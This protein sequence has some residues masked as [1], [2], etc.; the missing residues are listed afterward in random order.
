[1]PEGYNFTTALAEEQIKNIPYCRIPVKSGTLVVF[2]NYQMIHR[3]LR[4][5]YDGVDSNTP[6][7][8]ASRDFLM[9]FIVDQ[10][11][12]LI[13]TKSDLTISDDRFKVSAEMFKQQIKPSG[14][15]VPDNVTVFTEADGSAAQV[16]G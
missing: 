14:M 6:D 3:V 13:S 11:K 8:N 2:S 1:M 15:F 5:T 7:G 9:F 16:V 10:C 12:P 4:M